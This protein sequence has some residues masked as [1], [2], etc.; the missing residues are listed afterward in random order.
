MMQPDKHP[1]VS[2]GQAGQ[3]PHLPERARSVQQR[4]VQF[5]AQA[6]Q[7]RLIPGRRDRASPDVLPDIESGGVRP[8]GRA[9]AG[10]PRDE[11]LAQPGGEMEAPLYTPLHDVHP[12]VPG[13]IEKRRAFQDDQRRDVHRQAALLDA[14]IAHVQRRQPVWAAGRP[15]RGS[16]RNLCLFHS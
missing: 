8:G 11:H 4:F 7:G 6:E 13:L 2:I 14:Q 9:Q 5:R 3:E 10:A 12:Q 1:D 16:G 15:A